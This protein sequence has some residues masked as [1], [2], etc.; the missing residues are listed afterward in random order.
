M[1]D[2]SRR[3]LGFGW[4]VLALL[5]LAPTSIARA[6]PATKTAP[7]RFN[8]YSFLQYITTAN[9]APASVLR[10]DNNGEIALAAR[11]GITKEQLKATGIAYSE[12]Q[13]ALLEA[14]RLLAEDG[15]TLRTQFP[16]LPIQETQRLRDRTHRAAAE[17]S[18]RLEPKIRNLREEL[19]RTGRA[20]NSY[21]LV[22]SYVLDGLVWHELESRH[23]VDSQKISAETP[24]WSGV[25][26]ALYPPRTFFPGTNSLSDGG[27]ALKVA[28]TEQAIP[29]MGPFVA[30]F[31][32]LGQLFD[33]YKTKG[34]VEDA[35]AKEV[36]GPFDL[37]DRSGHLTIPVIVESDSNALYRSAKA[38]AE[39]VAADAPG[40]LDPAGLVSAFG[41]RDEQQAL[42]IAYH[43]LMWDTM[44]QLEALGLVQRPV[45]FTAPERAKPA[46]I[47]ALTFIV[48]KPG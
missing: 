22:F 38:I 29:K 9:L 37:F 18:R 45:A 30:D 32:T 43:E 14:W 26:W 16:I 41:F 46:D 42:V 47:A 35:H 27:V 5:L 8:D 40:L 15:D 33:D 21:I 20:A 7:P 11:R 19:S 6:Q 28:W 10:L 3:G 36:F 31:H 24:L 44:D 13:I 1:A 48:R 12:S 4:T 34:F 39:E 2:T 23:L 25:V 17:L